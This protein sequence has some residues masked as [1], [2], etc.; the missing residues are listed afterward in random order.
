MGRH[1]SNQVEIGHHKKL[2]HS[3]SP[4]TQPPTIYSAAAQPEHPSATHAD[5]LTL[6]CLVFSE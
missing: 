4:S 6:N 1:P 5:S 3:E 2:V